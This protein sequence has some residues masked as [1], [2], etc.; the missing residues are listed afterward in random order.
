MR[1]RRLAYLTPVLAAVALAGCGD[2]QQEPVY[3][4]TDSSCANRPTRE[5]TPPLHMLTVREGSVQV[6]R[7]PVVQHPAVGQLGW[8]SPS[9]N[10]R[11][12][13][14]DGSPVS[15]STV[16]GERREEVW[17]RVPEDVECRAYSYVVELW[18]GDDPAPGEIFRDTI[19][20][21][22]IEPYRW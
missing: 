14:L 21:D 5:V 4:G 2:A 15:A 22:E 6:G 19:N 13:Y 9:H 10:W 1:A 8:Y 7:D 3:L 18:Q 17:L 11:V 16:S 12:T 20:G